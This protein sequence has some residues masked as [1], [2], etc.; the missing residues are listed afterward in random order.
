MRNFPRTAVMLLAGAALAAVPFEVVRY[1]RATRA[2]AA[3]VKQQHDV[4]RDAGE[5]I[6][7]RTNQEV[8]SINPRPKENVYALLSNAVAASGI[9]LSVLRDLTPE[10]DRA[11]DAGRDPGQAGLR[12]QSMRLLLEPCSLAEFGRFA[13]VWRSEQPSWNFTSIE[14]SH[15]QGRTDDTYSCRVVMSA[16]YVASK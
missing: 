8:V 11:M 4:A 15:V 9:P 5:L 6:G 1:A 13:A 2:A 10:A 7:L 16:M 12:I 3:A 14:L